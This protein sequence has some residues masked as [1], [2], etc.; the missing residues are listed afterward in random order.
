[1]ERAV[2][3]H[4]SGIPCLGETSQ[5][6]CRHRHCCFTC[7]V[8]SIFLEGEH[9]LVCPAKECSCRCFDSEC[10][11]CVP[12][13]PICIRARILASVCFASQ[14]F[15]SNMSWIYILFVIV[16]FLPKEAKSQEP[17]SQWIL[18]VEFSQFHCCCSSYRLFH[19]LSFFILLTIPTYPPNVWHR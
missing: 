1:M 8:F 19:F 16:P 13:H 2:P 18:D 5:W 12:M 17:S 10:C 14:T 9:G 6:R 15:F 4:R 7:W 3:V 11:T